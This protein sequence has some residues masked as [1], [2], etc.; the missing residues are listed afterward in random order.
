M[1]NPLLKA[2]FK[3]KCL[4]DFEMWFRTIRATPAFR[5]WMIDKLSDKDLK[6]FGF[7]TKNEYKE[8]CDKFPRN[9]AYLW[10]LDSDDIFSGKVSSLV[11]F[12][13]YI[14]AGY[15]SFCKYLRK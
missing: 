4:V 8:M 10:K 13:T 3:G 5:V 2:L 15:E 7:K 14:P 9:T 1:T 6:E 11:N 12:P